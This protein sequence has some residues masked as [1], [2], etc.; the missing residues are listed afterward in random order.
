MA[1][2]HCFS[3]RGQGTVM[4]GTIHQGSVSVNDVRSTSLISSS[5]QFMSSLLKNE[6]ISQRQCSCQIYDLNFSS[7]I[8]VFKINS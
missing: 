3:I 2:D 4:T 6:F 7:T 8:L 5:Y 1:V